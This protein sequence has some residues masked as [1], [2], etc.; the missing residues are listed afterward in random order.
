MGKG[1]TA[2]ETAGHDELR[3]SLGATHPTTRHTVRSS[4][5]VGVED[6]P[7]LSSANAGRQ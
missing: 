5:G 4:E 6:C 2:I 1:I 7:A 3:A